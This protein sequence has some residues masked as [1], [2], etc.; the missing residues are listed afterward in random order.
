MNSLCIVLLLAIATIAYAKPQS[1]GK[2]YSNYNQGKYNPTQYKGW[3]PNCEVVWKFFDEVKKTPVEEC[4]YFT[5]TVT[6]CTKSYENICEEDWVCHEYPQP[7]DIAD[8]EDKEWVVSNSPYRCQKFKT[9]NCEDKP[10]SIKRCSVTKRVPKKVKG[11]FAFR[12][13]PGE[14]LYEYTP[15]E[16]Q[17]INFTGY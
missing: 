8:C 17:N 6:K 10:V 12:Q 5:E 15:S 1:Q 2:Y 9:D 7:K 14:D 3:K 11:K 13:C 4:E 16:A